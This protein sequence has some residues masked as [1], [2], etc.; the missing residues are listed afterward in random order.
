MNIS[1]LKLHFA[2]IHLCYCVVC[3]CIW[4]KKIFSTFFDVLSFTCFK[5]NLDFTW[6]CA[7]IFDVFT[8]VFFS[9]VFLT[10]YIYLCRVFVSLFILYK[11]IHIIYMYNISNEYWFF[12]CCMF[13]SH[14]QSSSRS[15]AICDCI[16]HHTISTDIIS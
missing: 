7:N 5:F 14:V 9:F 3:I 1:K 15:R 6:Q 13:R 8:F 16:I 2:F 10:L 12:D 4:K 11:N